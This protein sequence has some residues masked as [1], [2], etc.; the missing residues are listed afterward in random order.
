M[1]ALQWVGML[2]PANTPKQVI[3]TLNAALRE[4]LSS[5]EVVIKLETQGV[6]PAASSSEAF[7]ALISAELKQWKEIAAASGVQP[8]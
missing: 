4:V 7:Q 1:E 6:T 5:P 3:A 2:A 8:R